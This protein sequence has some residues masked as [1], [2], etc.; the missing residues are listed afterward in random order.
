MARDQ[1]RGTAIRFFVIALSASANAAEVRAVYSPAQY[2][3][4]FALSVCLSE[5]YKSDELVKDSRAAAGAYLE[6]GS[7]PFEAYEDVAALGRTFLARD[8]RGI[9]GQ[10]LMLMKCIDFFHSQELDR[11]TQRYIKK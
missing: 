2:L 5:A 4:N 11:L 10:P 1:I 6:L 7:L 3:K 9:S 8:Y